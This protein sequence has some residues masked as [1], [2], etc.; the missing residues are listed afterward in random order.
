MRNVTMLATAA[1]V[2]TATAARADS[3]PIE[4]GYYVRSDTPCQQASNATITLY[5]GISFGHAHVECRK[6]TIRKLADGSYQITERCKDTQG[7]GGPWTVFTA[8]YDVVGRTEFIG[9]TP[10][11]KASCKYC[12]QSDLPE[13]WS[14]NDLSSYGIK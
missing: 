10:Y 8:R 6:P 11:E 9:K 13:P 14:T 3:L 7:P 2:S 1:V 5:N 12:K 4:R